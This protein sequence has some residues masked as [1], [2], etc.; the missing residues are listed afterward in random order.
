MNDGPSPITN[1]AIEDI[2]PSG[3]SNPTNI[4]N[5]G[6][7]AGGVLTWTGINIPLP[8]GSTVDLT[9]DVT[10]EA[11]STQ[12]DTNYNNVAEVTAMDQVDLDSDE[13]NGCLLYTSP[14]P[15]D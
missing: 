3:Y 4:S 12:G 15:R 11:P 10:V 5:G 1:A 8:A 7:A 6:S 14:S 9:F 2:L 13:G